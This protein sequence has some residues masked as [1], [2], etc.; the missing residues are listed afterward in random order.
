MS[1][2]LI[3]FELVFISFTVLVIVIIQVFWLLLLIIQ[4]LLHV[5][6]RWS[7]LGYDR[8][9]YKWGVA[10]PI[11][12]GLFVFVLV[13]F[14]FFWGGNLTKQ[15]LLFIPGVLGGTY[16]HMG[17]LLALDSK[18]PVTPLLVLSTVPG[19]T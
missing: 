8:L 7:V 13:L 3:T 15:H 16:K 12:E 11:D 17:R 1:D 6:H 5:I 4:V 10:M 19:W 14:C 2:G 18:Q 9:R